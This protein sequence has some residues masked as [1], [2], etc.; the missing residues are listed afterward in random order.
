MRSQ[1]V[2]VTYSAVHV[3]RMLRMFALR[4]QPTAHAARSVCWNLLTSSSSS[5]SSSPRILTLIITQHKKAQTHNVYK[6][7]IETKTY[8]TIYYTVLNEYLL[9]FFLIAEGRRS[10]LAPTFSTSA[11]LSP[12]VNTP[13]LLCFTSL[14]WD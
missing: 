7:R 8:P 11:C 14:W 13:P 10:L 5:S 6:A 1:S 9:V 12:T 2:A 3:L 4:V